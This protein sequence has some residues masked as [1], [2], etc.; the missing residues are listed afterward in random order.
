ML[1]VLRRANALAAV[2]SRPFE[3]LLLLAMRLYVSW[4]FLISGWLKLQDWEST[5]FLFREEY[6]VPVLPP[7][8][9][10]VFGT[11][12]E[13][14]FPLLLVVGLLTRYAALGLA[15]VNVMAV[16]SY[17]HVLLAAGF[18]AAIGQHYLWGTLLLVI[19][20]FG[21]GRFALD[22]L[23]ERARR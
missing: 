8:A 14:L 22:S 12:G 21:P 15:L 2:A 18:E 9:A 4:Q 1:T 19:L 20:V 5:L 16:V 6:R 7:A 3:D 11:A 13:L 17:A 23:V 10:A